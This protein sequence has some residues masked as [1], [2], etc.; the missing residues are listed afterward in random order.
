MV[1]LIRKW[2]WEIFLNTVGVAFSQGPNSTEP[3]GMGEEL[4]Y[5]CFAAQVQ[6]LE[7]VAASELNSVYIVKV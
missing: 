1:L 4:Q 6:G 5:A 2:L 7:M 3:F